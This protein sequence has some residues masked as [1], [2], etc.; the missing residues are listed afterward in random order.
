M[1]LKR[2]LHVNNASSGTEEGLSMTDWNEEYDL[3]WVEAP[4]IRKEK[5]KRKEE[6][7]RRLQEDKNHAKN[8][9]NV[10]IRADRLVD[11]E[12]EV[13]D[14]RRRKMAKKAKMERDFQNDGFLVHNCRYCF[15]SPKCLKQMTVALGN[16]VRH[17]ITLSLSPSEF[18]WY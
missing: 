5:S 13:E 10:S 12:I 18:S 9:D 3:N 14:E 8:T 7:K 11:E 17:F 16:T 4:K 15:D 1:S 6:K 2:W